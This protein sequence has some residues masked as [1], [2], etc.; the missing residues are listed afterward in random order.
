MDILPTPLQ[1]QWDEGNRGKNIKHHVIDEEA[2]EV[3]IDSKKGLFDDIIHSKKEKRFGLF[4]ATKQ[5][6][7]LFVA[8]TIRSNCIR[9]ISARGMNRKERKEYEKEVKTSEI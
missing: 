4:G 2:E 7:L 1:F 8:F 3:F 9:V 6:R 5:G